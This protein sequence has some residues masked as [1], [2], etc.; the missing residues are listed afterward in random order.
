MKLFLRRINNNTLGLLHEENY[1][2]CCW[3]LERPALNNAKDDP[4]TPENESSRIPA[5]KYKVKWVKTPRFPKGVFQIQ[6]VPGRDGIAIHTANK[7]SQ[8]KGCLAPGLGTNRQQSKVSGSTDAL[9]ML[10][11]NLPKEWDL[12]IV[13]N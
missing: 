13:D 9:E 6:N 10:I 3:V 7:I 12:E 1:R 2:F 5:G 4:R 11:K 8:L